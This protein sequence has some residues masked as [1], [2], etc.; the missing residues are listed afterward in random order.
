MPYAAVQ[1]VP[2]LRYFLRL[3][4]PLPG[5]AAFDTLL[6]LI[7]F[8]LFVFFS[9]LFASRFRRAA[10]ADT[11]LPTPDVFLHADFATPLALTL[12]PILMITPT[13]RYALARCFSSLFAHRYDAPLSRRFLSRRC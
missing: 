13:F 10:D 3:S 9:P 2:L 7:Y 11:P 4:P 12:T 6:R 1:R 8:Q 5:H